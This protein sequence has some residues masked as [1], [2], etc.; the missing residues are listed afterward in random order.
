MSKPGAWFR[1]EKSCLK[2]SRTGSFA[3]WCSAGAKGAASIY[4]FTLAALSSPS[5]PSW[6]AQGASGAFA[7]A[8]DAHYA[9]L[10]NSGSTVRLYATAASEGRPA[11]LRKLDIAAGATA[12]FPGPPWASLPRWPL[13]P[14]ILL[15][16][17]RSRTLDATGLRAAVLVVQAWG[18]SGRPRTGRHHMGQPMRPLPGGAGWCR[19]TGRELCGCLRLHLGSQPLAQLAAAR[20]GDAGACLAD[21]LH[22]GQILAAT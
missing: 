21:L 22:A 19:Q 7:G 9:V 8:E 17:A 15:D 4:E 3:C 10:S 1:Q 11:V 16:K 20:S 12:L 13:T 5:K 6:T 14:G 2:E 18:R